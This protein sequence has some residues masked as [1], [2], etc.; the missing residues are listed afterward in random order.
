M[1]WVMLGAGICDLLDGWSARLLKVASPL[2][3]D[4][5][6]LADVVTF[7]V[8][9]SIALFQRTLENEFT[10]A[11]AVCSPDGCPMAIY[12]PYIRAAFAFFIALG[13]AWRLARFNN[14]PGQSEWFKG[15]PA[16]A[17]GLCVVALLNSS[18]FRLLSQDALR[19]VLLGLSCLMPFLM[20]SSL[21]VLSLKTPLPSPLRQAVWI[22]VSVFAGSLA[23][24]LKF[25]AAGP[26][27]AGF[28]LL[29]YLI[30]KTQHAIHC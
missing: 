27:L 10:G 21:P 15:L 28:L 8:A 26:L 11:S 1:W 19:F 24:L 23:L 16:P 5:D 29:S 17:S 20:L 4:L 12:L 22:G 30:K 6:S 9:P 2:G 13:A 14:D 3:K 7:G 18:L 25:D